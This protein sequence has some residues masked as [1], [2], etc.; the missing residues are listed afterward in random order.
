MPIIITVGVNII[1]LET[2]GSFQDIY[3]L[4][5]IDFPSALKTKR[6]SLFTHSFFKI[7]ISTSLSPFCRCSLSTTIVQT[8]QG[9]AFSYLFISLDTAVLHHSCH[10]FY[11]CHSYITYVNRMLLFKGKHSNGNHA[12]QQK[13]LNV[14][15]RLQ[16]AESKK[17]IDVLSK[18]LKF[19]EVK[20]Q[21]MVHILQS[22]ETSE[23]HEILLDKA[24]QLAEALTEVDHLRC[25]CRQ[26]QQDRKEEK[27]K[28]IGLRAVIRS[29][30]R[31]TDEE[32]HDD[33]EEDLVIE[34]DDVDVDNVSLNAERAVDMTLRYL[35]V[36]VEYLEEQ[37]QDMAHQLEVKDG[38][39]ENLEKENSLLKAKAELLGDIFGRPTTAGSHEV[40][41]H[42]VKVLNEEDTCTATT[43]A[44]ISTKLTTKEI[45]TPLQLMHEESTIAS[46]PTECTGILAFRSPSMV[47]VNKP[48]G[49]HKTFSDPAIYFS[50][51]DDPEDSM[52]DIRKAKKYLLMGNGS[53][54]LSSNNIAIKATKTTAKPANA[55]LVKSTKDVLSNSFRMAKDGI[56]RGTGLH[57]NLSFSDR[58]SPKD[59]LSKSERTSYSQKS[60]RSSVS[61]QSDHSIAS[62]KSHQSVNDDDSIAFSEDGE[63][64]KSKSGSFGSLRKLGQR[65]KSL[66][67]SS[68]SRDSHRSKK[69]LSWT[70]SPKKYLLGT[71]GN[72]SSFRVSPQ[73]RPQLTNKANSMKRLN[74]IQSETLAYLLR[75][76]LDALDK[77]FG[78]PMAY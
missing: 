70:G 16:L 36:R 58:A 11:C 15:L 32:V 54:T 43:G 68:L 20:S 60:E 25:K 21:Q 67:K 28:L 33:L 45:N 35:K 49:P 65:T 62:H 23:A 10:L 59:G 7:G 17:T 64:I 66:M 1:Y 31:L 75:K 56:Q 76:E 14:K 6:F 77:E 42:S 55:L 27:A 74:S 4:E 37:R 63:T 46:S 57:R 53:S 22:F 13:E 39:I 9:K 73:A 12:Q 18:D 19:Q 78:P 24:L 40:D 41:S 47:P 48:E 71:S 2:T 34:D 44:T 51:Q 38:Q 50:D 72:S 3:Y 69:N 30:Q 29:L 8:Q 61:Q 52:D 26:M 5:W